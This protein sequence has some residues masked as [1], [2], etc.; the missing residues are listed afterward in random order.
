MLT[1][2]SHRRLANLEPVKSDSL[3]ALIAL[4]NADT[5]KHKI[6]V[7]VGV[8]K[9]GNGKT[10]VMR[11]VKAAEKLLWETAGQQILSRRRRGHGVPQ[12]DRAD[13][14]WR[15]FARRPDPRAPDAR[16]VRGAGAGAEAGRRR[17]S[18]TR[19]C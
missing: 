10:P 8:Y 17:Q 1:A 15:A 7:G 18:A 14:A 13:P 4:A 12:A 9:D 11:S 5:R 3:L 16:R 6:D 2:T 19:A